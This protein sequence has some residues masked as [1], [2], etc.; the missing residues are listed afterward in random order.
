MNVT[1]SRMMPTARALRGCEKQ[2]A[3]IADCLEV[4][5]EQTYGFRMKA[6]VADAS[7][8]E[9]E[10]LYTDEEADFV[11]E[12]LTRIGRAPESGEEE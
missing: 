2:L 1:I 7:G 11:R 5:V 3:R 12:Y 4:I 6:T 8:P 9:P 10:A